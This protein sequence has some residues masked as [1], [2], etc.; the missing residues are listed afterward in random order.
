[1][2]RKPILIVDDEKNIR[3]TLAQSLEPL[4]FEIDT[5]VNGEEALEK[6]KNADFELLLLDLR[7]PGMD[8]MEVL[9]RIRELRPDIRIIMLTAYGTI[10]LAVT[11]LKLGAADFIQKPFAPQ[12]IRDAVARVMERERVPEKGA[13]EYVSIIE[14]AHKCI[15]E[16]Y[17]DS[18]LEHL[19]RAVYFDPSRPEA[20]NL[21]GAV[22]EIRR[23]LNEAR[24][25]YRAALSL[26]PT[27]VP[28]RKN[29]ERATSFHRTEAIDL[30]ETRREEAGVETDASVESSTGTGSEG[31]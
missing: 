8:G 7:L 16:R 5:A 22:L 29:L 10:D 28:A 3:L 1:M 15:N 6:V 2:A 23:D 21:M 18:A 19:R 17:F 12:E 11:A 27:Y 26:D 13:A 24:K 9:R 31:K 20:F 25:H 14:L 30:G 4:G